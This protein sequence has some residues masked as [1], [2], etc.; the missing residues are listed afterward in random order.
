MKRRVLLLVLPFVVYATPLLADGPF[1]RLG[2]G[3]ENTETARFRDRDCSLPN[4][5]FG[6]GTGVD[7]FGRG[8]RGD[9]GS[10][11]PVALG[12]GYEMGPHSR[13]EVTVFRRQL[14]LD[15]DGNLQEFI[16]LPQD[17]SGEGHS[18]AGLFIM[19]WDL[20]STRL[21]PFLSVGGGIA[22]NS[23]GSV[24]IAAPVFGPGTSAVVRGGGDSNFAWT[25]GGG[26][27]LWISPMVSLDATFR[28]TDLGQ[29][30]TDDGEAVVTGPTGQRTEEVPGMRMDLQT[31]GVIL[32]VRV[33]M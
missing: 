7:Q 23:I 11:V 6:C 8:A 3:I 4:S 18:T 32:S 14:K 15:A 33:R 21:R 28:W 29:I 10:P 1:L 5:V 13:L 22:R 26:L 19:S 24:D 20:S 27:S 12:V 17:V 31:S 16:G 2:L 9:L 25:A 30:E